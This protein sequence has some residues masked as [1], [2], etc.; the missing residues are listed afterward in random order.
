MLRW[1]DKD[2][3]DI[4]TYELDLSGAIG[5]DTVSDVTWSVTT[6]PVSPSTMTL[7]EGTHASGLCQVQIEGGTAGQDYVIRC[8]AT[9][10]SGAVIDQSLLLKVREK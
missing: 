9:L 6:D 3:D 7:T 2:P 4:I 5:D 8:R 10:T 1:P